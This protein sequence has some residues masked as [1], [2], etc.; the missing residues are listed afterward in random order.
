MLIHFY[1]TFN[2]D[3]FGGRQEIYIL[4]NYLQKKQTKKHQPEH[5][6]R[7]TSTYSCECYSSKHSCWHG[8]ISSAAHGL[9]HLPLPILSGYPKLPEP[10]TRV[11]KLKLASIERVVYALDSLFSPA[12]TAACVYVCIYLFFVLLY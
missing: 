11:N 12:L 3:N 1:Y 9:G 6:M 10:K 5:E 8:H 4:C 7:S 2:C